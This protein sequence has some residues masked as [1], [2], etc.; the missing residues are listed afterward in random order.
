MKY[1][2]YV[3][4]ASILLISSNVFGE[5]SDLEERFGMVFEEKLKPFYHGVASGDPL[6]DSV[7]IWTRVTSESNSEV[8]VKWRIA[9]DSALSRVVKSGSIVTD[10]SKDYTVRVDVTGLQPDMVYYYG[11]T[12]LGRH[13]LTG[14]TKTAPQ[15]DVDHAKFAVITGSNYQWGLFNGYARIA[16]RDD[17]NAFI[18]TGDYLYEYESAHYAHPDRINRDHY[19]DKELLTLDDYR[20]RYSQYRMDSDLRRLHQQLP[21]I[22]QWD[23]HEHANDCWT[24][25]A[26]NH[27]PETEGP[28][29]DRLAN[30]LQAYYEWMP[31]R[32]AGPDDKNIYRTFSYGNLLDLIML[33][34][35]IAGRDQQL[36]PKGGTGEI[37]PDELY[38][39]DR[40]LLGQEQYDWLVNELTTSEAEWKILGSSVMM[41]Q[42]FGFG[43]YGNMDS[44]DGY[45]VE[46]GN[47]FQCIIDNNIENF[48]VLSGDFHMAFAANLVP[49][50]YEG[51]N[52]ETGSGAV[53]F[54]FVTPSITSANMNEQEALEIP[55]YGIVYPLEERW[56]ERYPV[57]LMVEEMFLNGNPQMKYI[58]MDQHGYMLVDF[59]KEKVQADWYYVDNLLESSDNEFFAEGWYVENGS[60]ML[61]K[62]VTPVPDVQGFPTPAPLN[63]PSPSIEIALLGRCETGIFDESAAEIAAHDPGTQRLFVVNGDANAIDVL[64]M[65]DPEH[66][67]KIWD[68]PLGNYGAA[69]T[70]IA[71]SSGI[72]AVAMEN[73]PAQD[74]GKVVFFDINGV[75]L[76]SV[77]VG[78]LPDMVIFTP[79]GTKVLAANEGEPNDEYTLDPEGSVSIIDISDGVNSATVTTAGFSAFNAQAEILK[80]AGVRIFGAGATVAQD[81][82]PEYIAVSK[83]SKKAWISLQENNA[84]A[85]LNISSGQITQILPFGFKDWS[86]SNNGLDASNRDNAINIDTY[87]NLFGMYQPDAIAVFEAF[88][89]QYL[90]TANEG[91]A[92]DYEGFSEEKR[93][94]KLTL[95]PEAFPN[96]GELQQDEV[97]GRLKVTNALGDTDSDGDFDEL[98]AYGARSFSIFRYA[99]SGLELVFDSGDQFEQI[100]AAVLPEDFNSDNDENNS[101]DSRSDDKGPE[102]EGVTTGTIKGHTF[103][104]IGLERIG[105][106][107]VYDVTTPAAPKFVQ[108][109]NTRDF[110]GDPESGTAGDLGPEGLIFIPESQSPNGKPLL[111]V[112]YEVSGST[113]IYE[114][115]ADNLLPAGDLDKDGDV[116]R[117]D[118]NIIKSHRKLPASQCPECDIDGDG[119]ITVR[120]A[121]KL[122]GMCTRPRCT[123][124]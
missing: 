70:S 59:S 81:L 67:S 116:D 69:P 58:N 17:L 53:G 47:L 79:D 8:E 46:R 92:R 65:S 85:V 78:A 118:V 18:H 97:L 51:Y 100:I 74:P 35:R 12:A 75:F 106:I 119:V 3:L 36:Q 84:V 76:K 113:S 32:M 104:F 42:L 89:R 26:Q 44:W 68:I 39:P 28:W 33:E 88:G 87:A 120:D 124:E 7:I 34:E 114:I 50:P 82:E 2:K 95:D 43:P 86:F 64:S 99:P 56:P 11:F 96:A 101:F 21:M 45:P 57:T 108:Y 25:G 102:P 73:N 38:D 4:T 80:A 103:A 22:A 62:T 90:I 31:I 54:E 16:E 20:K 63:P 30:S 91:D 49:N 10:E 6:T 23:D 15:G 110:S 29:E 117:N 93:V 112:A 83:D 14:R 37:D 55:G 121:R 13:S 52:P 5:Q 107:M 27:D 109:I 123:C 72:V 1:L 105:G 60:T 48:G 61:Q 41:Q 94:G 9:M 115:N 77:T 66:L 19:P 111:V 40:T 122:V 71:V 98:Y 24:G